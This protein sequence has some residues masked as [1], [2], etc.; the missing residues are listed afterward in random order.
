MYNEIVLG[1]DIVADILPPPEYIVETYLTALQLLKEIKA[2]DDLIL[3]A[4]RGN[5]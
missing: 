1:K 2:P 4:D 5:R 3:A